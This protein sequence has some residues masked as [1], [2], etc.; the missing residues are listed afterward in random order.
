MSI[1]G[2]AAIVGVGT[3]EQGELPDR[4]ADEVAVRHEIFEHRF[5]PRLKGRFLLK[6]SGLVGPKTPA[7]AGVAELHP[8]GGSS[9]AVPRQVGG[10]RAERRIQV[11]LD[12]AYQK[13]ANRRPVFRRRPVFPGV[14]AEGLAEG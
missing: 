13:L 6:I 2:K 8:Q 7:L 10:G 9:E 14:H 3:T 12:E 11:A 5:L 1:R 4:S